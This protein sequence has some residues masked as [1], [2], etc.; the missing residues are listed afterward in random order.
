MQN[1][2]TKKQIREAAESFLPSA[3]RLPPFLE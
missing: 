2:E 3:F 1:E